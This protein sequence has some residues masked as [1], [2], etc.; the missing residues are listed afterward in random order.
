MVNFH[1]TVDSE[2]DVSSVGKTVMSVAVT[3]HQN[4]GHPV[5]VIDWY[6]DV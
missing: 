6:S 2:T 4:V 1:R 3:R 5:A